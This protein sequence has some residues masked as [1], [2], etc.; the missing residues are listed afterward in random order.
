MISRRLIK[1]AGVSGACAV[2]LLSGALGRAEEL[3]AQNRTQAVR[4]APAPRAVQAAPL[5]APASLD[6]ETSGLDAAALGEQGRQTLKEA[7]KFE[8]GDFLPDDKAENWRQCALDVPAAAAFATKRSEAWDLFAA[9]KK[10]ADED[11]QRRLAEKR[12]AAPAAAPAAPAAGTAIS[13]VKIP[14]GTF[15]M[16]TNEGDLVFPKPVHQVKIAA[17]EMA[18]HPV[19]NKQYR[20]CV[21]AK[22]C[23]TAHT[24]DG[25]CYVSGG[26]GW[27]KGILPASFLG[28]DQ[29]AVCVSWEQANAFA[30]W[31]G[32][33]LPTEAER[34]YAARSG[35]KDQAFPWGN[36][37]ATC[38]RAVMSAG[39]DGCGRKSTWPV[40]SLPLG[41]TAQ[42]LCD[43]SGNVWEWVSDRFHPSY[44]GAP[45]D[46]SSWDV[47]AKGETRDRMKRG[48]SWRNQAGYMRSAY[49][50]ACDPEHH[51]D[52]NGFRLVRSAR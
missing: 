17:F 25:T 14:G 27:T 40:C 42:G 20:A 46:G 30:K 52:Y 7:F 23:T 10:A 11:A 36:E 15:M 49:R 4:P 47:Q 34:E 1:D 44:E 5:T 28:D 35:G 16:G 32:G 33:R 9:R 8:K 37:E 45:K 2:L 6:L 26:K 13:W 3:L 24:A 18:K 39:G 12:A 22:G 51:H 19:T 31:A 48:G 41:N 21:A 43:M 38:E 50:G 29:P